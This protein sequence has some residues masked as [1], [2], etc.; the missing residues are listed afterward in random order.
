MAPIGKALGQLGHSLRTRKHV[1]VQLGKG[2]ANSLPPESDG[3]VPA[4]WE[5]QQEGTHPISFAILVIG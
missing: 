5:G 4:N 3:G 2:F 1:T